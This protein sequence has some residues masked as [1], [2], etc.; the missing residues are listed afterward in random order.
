VY[1]TDPN[2]GEH[3]FV[4]DLA[5]S[6]TTQLVD[7]R[8]KEISVCNNSLYFF[9]EGSD[10]ALRRLDLADG[11]ITTLSSDTYYQL[12]ATPKGLFA[13]NEQGE[14][15]ILEV[16][17]GKGEGI[18]AVREGYLSRYCI[19]NDWILYESEDHRW[20]LW[21]MRLDGT[22]DHAFTPV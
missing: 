18:T 14:S 20:D 5:T 13:V 12:N 4:F 8:C 6:T 16:M 11:T 15:Y 22:E 21:M 7:S 1:F 10:R 2:D 9:D 19:A 17:D 3:L